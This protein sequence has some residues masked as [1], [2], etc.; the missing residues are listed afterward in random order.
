M[1]QSYVRCD[2]CGK[3]FSKSRKNVNEW[4]KHGWR[5][6]CSMEC[7]VASRTTSVSCSCCNCSKDI[8]KRL[9]QIKR[10][11]SGNVFCNRTCATSY[12]NRTLR[13]GEDH[14]N[15]VDGASSY[16]ARALR[17]CGACVGCGERRVYML[18]VHHIDGDR[19]NNS[20]ENTET[21]CANCHLLRHLS[22]DGETFVVNFRV[23]T[24]RELLESLTREHVP[25]SSNG[26]DG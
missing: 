16:R 15:W 17:E 24:N 22:W 18:M 25:R 4:A 14:P 10:S 9:S 3:D 7:Q 5:L 12:H 6:F 23:L 26:S 21:V 11:K 1:A 13:S 20:P 2:H 19:N 8:V